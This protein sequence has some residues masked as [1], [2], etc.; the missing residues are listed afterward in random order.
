[1]SKQDRQGVRT[2]ADVERKY[3]LSQV[4]KNKG[5]T[6]KQ[7]SRIN[8]LIQSLN[9]LIT[10]ITAEFNGLSDK[11]VEKV[12]K[13]DSETEYKTL[14]DNDL[15]DELKSNYD[16]AYSHSQSSH[17]PS[18]AQKNVIE[19]VKVNGVILSIIDKVVNVLVPTKVSELDN[20]KGYLTQHQDLSG[21]V[22]KTEMPTKVSAFEND[23]GYLTQ[24][25]DLSAYAKKTEI[26]SVPTK[27]SA[28]T[29]DKG[30]LTAESD[31]TVPAWA[32]ASSKPKYTASEVGAAPSSHNH[33]G[34]YFRTY[35]L[36]E[37]NIDSTG[38]CWSVDISDYAH[39]SVPEAWV[40][41]HQF[42]GGHFFAQIAIKCDN[43]GNTSRKTRAMWVRNKYSSG[44][45][46]AW[47]GI[48]LV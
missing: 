14:S 40:N 36:N 28:F 47:T 39:G 27:V 8:Q 25:Q 15:T 3:N 34:R 30:Y 48:S 20:D 1:M 5:V 11:F 13:T 21:Y 26:P 22:K 23:K 44:A 4:A 41:V 32:K 33:D 6:E 42:S 9:Q 12:L 17:A 10:N 43:D 24:H 19:G 2:P 46:S 38:G 18:N 29:N 31:P 7:E 37:I 35:G 45:W 16:A